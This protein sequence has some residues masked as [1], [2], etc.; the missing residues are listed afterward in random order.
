MAQNIAADLILA[1]GKPA[2][3]YFN[4]DTGEFE[5]VT[6][7]MMEEIIAKEVQGNVNVSDVNAT[8]RLQAIEDKLNGTLDTNSTLTGSIVEYA[9]EQSNLDFFLTMAA[10]FFGQNQTQSTNSVIPID[11][12]GYNKRSIYIKNNHDVA[13]DIRGIKLYEKSSGGHM[14]DYNITAGTIAIPSGASRI[15]TDADIPQLN[16]LIKYMAIYLQAS[17]ATTGS[18]NFKIIGGR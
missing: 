14:L 17:N 8:S 13:I 7:S 18:F 15:I 1:N 9:W 10:G 16:S 11:V 2:P 12:S 3:Q 5:V 6:K 4:P